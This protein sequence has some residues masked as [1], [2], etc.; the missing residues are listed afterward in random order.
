[1]NTQN[2]PVQSEENLEEEHKE[3]PLY[4]VDKVLAYRH[5]PAGS[6]EYLLKWKG[7]REKD[8]SWEPIENLNKELQRL[9]DSKEIDIW[10]G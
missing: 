10:Q 2:L 1:V 6:K 8:N 9:V 3:E 4:I 7:Y 5:T